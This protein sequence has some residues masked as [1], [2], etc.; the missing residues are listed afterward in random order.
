MK[1]VLIKKNGCALYTT[2]TKYNN[3]YKRLGYKLVEEETYDLSKMTYQELQALY[4]SKTDDSPVG[5][6]KVDLIERLNE[7]L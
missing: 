5:V 7:V 4:S 3:E 2:M 1:E 6:S